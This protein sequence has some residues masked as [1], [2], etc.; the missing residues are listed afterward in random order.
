MKRDPRLYLQDIAQSIEDIESY[1]VGMTESEFR[2]SRL[3]QDAVVRRLEIIGEAARQ[4]PAEVRSQYPAIPWRRIVG[5]RNRLTHE[6]FGILIERI[7]H[8]IERD[9]PLLKEAM[10]TM[11]RDH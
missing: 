6:Y 3:V 9:L 5:L 8:V 1:T 2:A 11:Q 10:T 7:W 4:L